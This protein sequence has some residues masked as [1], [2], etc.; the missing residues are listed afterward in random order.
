VKTV[1]TQMTLALKKL[2][3]SLKEYHHL[4]LFFI[5]IGKGI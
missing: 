5:I 2:R 3:D 4:V 1:E